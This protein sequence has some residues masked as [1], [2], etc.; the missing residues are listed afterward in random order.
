MF[1]AL[2]AAAKLMDFSSTFRIMIKHHNRHLTF[3]NTVEDYNVHY[4]LCY[5]YSNWYSKAEAIVKL[6]NI[7]FN[8]ALKRKHYGYYETTKNSELRQLTSLSLNIAISSVQRIGFLYE[9][10][11]IS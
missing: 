10:S 3:N 2:H 7:T 4:V 1:S 6:S 5:C 9:V 8:F 11:I